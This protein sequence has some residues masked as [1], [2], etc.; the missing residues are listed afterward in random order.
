MLKQ[1]TSVGLAVMTTAC[2]V[3]G[4]RAGT[5]EP[6]FQVIE[7]VGDLEIRRYGER[8][9]A[10]TDVTGS[11]EQGRSDGFRR[12]AGYIFGG[13][14]KNSSIAMTAPVEQKSEKIAMTAPVAQAAEGA[15][16]W[17]IQFYMPSQ[18]KL[19]DLPT[20]KDSSVHLVVVPPATYAVLVFSGSPSAD[21]M[22]TKQR[23]LQAKLAGTKWHAIGEPVNWFYDPPW[24]LPPL[25]RNEVA[26]QVEA[27]R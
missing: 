8:I 16:A 12:L 18:Y 22:K 27:S 3:V 17:K 4:V 21:L 14:V 6:K 7:R 1:L 26:V 9:A 20:P 2:S 11:D 5:E 15:G 10:E 24:T 23:E 19:S 13:N 25:R